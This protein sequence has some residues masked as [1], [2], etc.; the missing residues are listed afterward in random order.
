MKKDAMI[1]HDKK[2][3]KYKKNNNSWSFREMK[4]I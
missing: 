3:K 1:M 4:N 2:W